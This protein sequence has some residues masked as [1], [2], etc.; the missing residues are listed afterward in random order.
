MLGWA[1]WL[2]ERR[3]WVGGH[4]TPSQPGIWRTLELLAGWLAL[5]PGCRLCSLPSHAHSLATLLILLAS[6][7]HPAHH[8]SIYKTH[9]PHSLLPPLPP[10]RLSPFAML[11]VARAALRAR[12]ALA[13]VRPAAFTG[14]PF[15]PR[16]A[17]PF[18]FGSTGFGF[19]LGAGFPRVPVEM[20][21]ES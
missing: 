8:S 15:S 13:A 10:S 12:P 4:L 20:D 2:A 19:L 14:E 6:T 11:T 7:P 9:P 1:G 17:A 18:S 5:L 3:S 21:A 16:P